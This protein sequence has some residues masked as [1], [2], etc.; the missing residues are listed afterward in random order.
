MEGQA[1]A[2]AAEEEMPAP[3]EELEEMPAPAE[4]PA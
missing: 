2:Q 4:E 3:A 1:A